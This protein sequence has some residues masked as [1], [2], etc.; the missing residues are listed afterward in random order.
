[1]FIQTLSACFLTKATYILSFAPFFLSFAQ[2]SI[3]CLFLADRDQCHI[4]LANPDVDLLRRVKIFSFSLIPQKI[5]NK[6]P[7]FSIFSS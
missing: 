3:G 6:I 7:S 5:R 4:P 1:M 2:F